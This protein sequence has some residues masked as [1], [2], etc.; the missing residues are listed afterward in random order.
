M[1]LR[2]LVLVPVC[3]SSTIVP[4]T[5]CDRTQLSLRPPQ[6]RP[7]TRTHT[8]YTL[9]P[10]KMATRRHSPPTSAPPLTLWNEGWGIVSLLLILQLGIARP[11]A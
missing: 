4:L 5:G 2:A 1:R 7:Q 3:R 11:H 6:S 8:A 9:P 10:D